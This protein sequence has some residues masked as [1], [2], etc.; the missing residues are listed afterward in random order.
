MD[1]SEHDE[2]LYRLDERTERVDNH[3]NR[4]DDIVRE[5][6]REI[7]SIKQT[8]RDNRRDIDYGKALIGFFSAILTAISAKIFGVIQP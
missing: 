5:N 4:L 7:E 8:S 3:L 6:E 2:I 1:E